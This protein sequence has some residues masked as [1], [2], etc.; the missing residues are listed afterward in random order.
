MADE[1]NEYT[2]YS[3]D[4]SWNLIVAYL[5]NGD[6]EKAKFIIVKLIKDNEDTSIAKVAQE[7]LQ[8]LEKI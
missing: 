3:I 1:Y 2:N 4:I 5:K 7:L 8:R 6:R